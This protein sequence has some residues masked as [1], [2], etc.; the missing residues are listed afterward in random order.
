MQEIVNRAFVDLEYD[1]TVH[2][3]NQEKQIFPTRRVRFVYGV[4]RQIP[5]LE[6]AIAG[7]KKG[8]R[9]EIH[10]PAHKLAGEHDSDLV[11]EIPKTG[12]KKNRLEVGRVYRE[13]RKGCLY[14]FTPLEIRETTVL[15]D[16]NRPSSGSSAD[17]NVKIHD[18]REATPE[19][20]RDAM[21]RLECATP[22]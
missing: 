16:F 12:L 4:E 1:Y 14:T 5:A 9:I 6:D 15:A 7:G 17:V 20:I 3:P 22:A 10:I 19:D 8:D 21:N 2:Y 11:M 18:V 13:I